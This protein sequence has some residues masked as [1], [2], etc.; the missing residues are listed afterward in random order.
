MSII[1]CPECG[2]EIS[3]E[4]KICLNCGY[5][6]KKKRKKIKSINKKILILGTVFFWSDNCNFCNIILFNKYFK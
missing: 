6:I 5:K 2:K 3:S 1:K 4:T